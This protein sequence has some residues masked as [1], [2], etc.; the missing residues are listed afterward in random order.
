[1]SSTDKTHALVQKWG[2]N[3]ADGPSAPAAAVRIDSVRAVPGHRSRGTKTSAS[4]SGADADDEAGGMQPPPRRRQ[5]TSTAS[6]SSS[7]TEG[8]TDA[9]ALDQFRFGG[10]D[11][12]RGA[13]HFPLANFDS[14]SGGKRPSAA[15][16]SRPANRSR[17]DDV[18]DEDEI[19]D[20]DM[21]QSRFSAQPRPERRPRK[22]LHLHSQQQLP[23]APPPQ[24]QRRPWPGAGIDDDDDDDDIEEDDKPIARTSISMITPPLPGSRA[25]SSNAGAA[26]DRRRSSIEDCIETS[27][28]EMAGGAAMCVRISTFGRSFHFP[29]GSLTF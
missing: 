22:V 4:D 7:S 26:G 10:S 28:D 16:L 20:I 12:L 6:P 21:L 29:L 13:G 9:S 2:Y 5:K 3:P 11:C 15:V 14:S 25:N 1:M 18:E 27:D 23:L 17:A 8:L 19:V 24:P